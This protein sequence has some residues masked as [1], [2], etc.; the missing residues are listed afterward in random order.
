MSILE[1]VIDGLP[2]RRAPKHH[3]LVIQGTPGWREDAACC[4]P[5][6]I[7][8]WQKAHGVAKRVAY[9]VRGGRAGA[10]GLN[11]ARSRP[12]TVKSTAGQQV[13]LWRRPGIPPEGLFGRAG[14]IAKPD[15]LSGPAAAA[16]VL[17]NASCAPT[18]VPT[19]DFRATCWK[20]ASCPDGPSIFRAPGGLQ[21]TKVNA[22]RTSARCCP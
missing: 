22:D 15:E 2:K 1:L 11:D 7:S 21:H 3:H 9:F 6:A 16:E 17:E 14:S 20:P 12:L 13:A 5:P 10:A 4:A 8:A 18:T 19:K